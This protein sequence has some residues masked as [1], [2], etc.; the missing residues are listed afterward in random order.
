MARDL[1]LFDHLQHD[2]SSFS[3]LLLADKTLRRQSG[4]ERVGIDAE[5]ADVGVGGDEVETSKVFA[6]R[7][8]DDWLRRSA[9]LFCALR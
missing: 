7:D 1:A 4:L 5:A 8:G 2:R 6:L 9:A 3:R